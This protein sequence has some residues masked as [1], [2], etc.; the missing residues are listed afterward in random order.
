MSKVAPWL[1]VNDVATAVSFYETAFGAETVESHADKAGVLQVARVMVEGAEVW[2]SRDTANAPA[3]S[4]GKEPVHMIL[5]V[6][7]PDA[8]FAK[9]LEAGATEVQ[10]VR[11]DYGWRIGRLVDPAGHGWEVGKPLG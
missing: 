9:A 7:D 11:D 2:I 4:D 3:A 10:A 8:V 5:T 1:S 6:D